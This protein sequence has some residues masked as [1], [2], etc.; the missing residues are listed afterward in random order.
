MESTF[1][2]LT[3]QRRALD[4]GRERDDSGT[5]PGVGK[6]TLI[7]ETFGSPSRPHDLVGD[8]VSNGGGRLPYLE[9]IQRSFGRHDVSGVSAH[10]GPSAGQ[11]AT[12]LGARAFA[13]GNAV[14]F[15]GTPDLHTAAHEA[16]H[17]VQQRGGVQLKGGIGEVGDAHEQHANQVADRVVAGSSAEELLDRYTSGSPEVTARAPMTSRAF[18]GTATPVQRQS[19]GD[20]SSSQPATA[21]PAN[22]A[23]DAAEAPSDPPSRHAT[24]PQIS[25]AA[26]DPK[27]QQELDIAW[28]ASLPDHLRESID[29]AFA[30]STAEA[31]VAKTATPG[32]AKI[33]SEINA[34]EKGLA[35]RTKKRLTEEH[36]RATDKDVTADPGYVAERDLLEQDRKQ[37]KQEYLKQT[38]AAN[39]ASVEMK[40]PQQSVARPETPTVKRLEGKALARTNFMS[41]AVHIFGS[42]EA[43]KA[44]FTGIKP[45]KGHP[46]MW[47]AASA[48]ARFESA[49]INFEARH[50]GYTIVDTSVANDLRG[51]HQQRWGIGMLG[52]ALGEAID[53]KAI[54]NPNIKIDDAGHSYGYLIG[55][56]GGEQGKRGTGR[57]KMSISEAAIE[58]TG[59]EAVAGKDTP[60]GVTLVES[61]RQQFAEM[62]ATSERLKASMAAEMPR[63]QAARDLYFEQAGLRV[64][65]AK[66]KA[67]LAHADAAA[68]KRLA[69]QK[70][71]DPEA[72]KAAIKQIK[73]DLAT[74][75]D[76]K[77]EA[78]AQS[79]AA[80]Q[81]A[82][83]DAFAGWTAGIQG[84]ID[85]DQGLLEQNQ[86]SRNAMTADEQALAA[87]DVG[88]EGAKTRLNQFAADHQ[89]T[90]LDKMKRAPKDA[91]AY[92]QALVSE[93]KTRDGK[94]S[95]ALGSRDAD[96]H[97]D[98]KELKFYQQK[99]M[100]PAFV[101][102]RGEKHDD[103][104]WGSKYDVSQVPLMQLLEHGTVRDDPMPERETSEARKGVYNAEVV[105]TLARFGWA[106][107]ANFGDTMHFD[108]I[109]GYSK[110]VP[111]GRSPQNMK[112][113]RYSPEGD[114]PP[115]APASGHK[116]PSKT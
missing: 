70:F 113:T 78:L 86:A 97:A 37:R 17:V 69:G 79:Q 15:D 110:D 52:H 109:E 8:A 30:D 116:D 94:A 101:F 19:T 4:A 34:A 41:W 47:L 28:I 9:E 108:F 81:K 92:K 45:V 40:Q 51:T 39:D 67:D 111:G 84:D 25:G 105:A 42:A 115:P 107:G 49:Q 75:L 6:H 32:L 96:A 55:K 46:N 89:L 66:A 58:K 114:L 5:Q 26:E 112:R 99:L 48:R 65:L 93:L 104:H 85:T 102:G 13:V 20:S 77:K 22:P 2:A 24:W 14:A 21:A 80:V 61:V 29:V 72:K 100:D 31:H 44:H 27:A 54:D 12:A 43:V 73:Q 60:E 50:P 98:I 10:Q 91:K 7:E 103:G 57:A 35:K 82:L 11:A 106:P 76:Q 18:S 87:I 1:G 64:E 68:N 63:L 71:D 83:Q 33:D 3:V 62:S 59:K 90:T 23:P 38:R 74:E 95:K 53:L 88:G 56:F 36:K 16:A